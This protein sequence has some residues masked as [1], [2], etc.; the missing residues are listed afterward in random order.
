M[1]GG[2]E[3]VE[4][5]VAENDRLR[6]ENDTLQAEIGELR[7]LIGELK[8]RVADLESK[9]G[10]TSKTSSIPPSRDP[11]SAR[12]EAKLNRAARRA[13]ARRQGKQPGSEGKH[14]S[15]RSVVDRRVR[16]R[17][18]M[19][20][21][22]GADLAGAKVVGGETRQ[23]FD[24]P[25]ITIEVTEHVAERVVCGC[26]KVSCG[27][28]P[29]E[30]TAPACWGPKVKA[31]GVYLTQRQHIPYMRAAEM[32]SD[33]L[34]APVSTGFLAG[35][36]TQAARLL[37]PFVFRARELL[38]ANP[39]I[40]ADETTLRV[41][42]KSFWLH[43]MASTWVTLL[44]LH[45][46]RGREAIGDID[47]LPGY[48][49]V[50]VHDGLAAYDYLD[51]AAHAQ[52]GA[53]LVRH[54][55]AAMEHDDTKLWA[56]LMTEALLAA[57]TAARRSGERGKTRVPDTSAARLRERYRFALDVASRTLPVG[58]PPPRRNTG[59]WEG[60]QRDAWNL[61]KRMRDDEAD[62]LRFLTDTRIPF[63]NNNAERPLRPAKL[64]DKISGTFRSVAHAKA[65]AT[66]RSYLGTADKHDK[67][68]Y[69]ALTELFTTGAWLPPDATP[70]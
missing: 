32:L 36:V 12:E 63:S 31:L 8:S 44:V 24:L 41:E 40:H 51:L 37:E 29:V 68:L 16:H 10:R 21:G 5:L 56:R 18:A 15:Q 1:A 38:S 33:V 47:L 20:A 13:A 58:P 19:C 39:V 59:G 11:N 27:V 34:G 66:I 23:V 50:I 42:S 17:P 6:A 62:I 69:Q 7:G 49:G 14:L 43:V 52:C 65:F 25:E 54:L 53:H 2:D 61:A 60:H 45:Q 30:A 48:R 9:S 28:F 46:R 67:N 3:V 70:G 55:A 22:C 57:A 4:R 64:H 35:L 26:G